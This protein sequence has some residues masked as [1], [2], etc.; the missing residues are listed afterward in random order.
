MATHFKRKDITFESYQKEQ[1]IK[2]ATPLTNLTLKFDSTMRPLVEEYSFPGDRF[3]ESDGSLI[4]KT[5]MPEDGWMY[6]FLLS[7]GKLLTVV[8]PAHVRNELKRMTIEI[9]HKY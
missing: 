9:A 3:E 2:T 6:S 8:E 5:A 1:E 7:Y 4:V